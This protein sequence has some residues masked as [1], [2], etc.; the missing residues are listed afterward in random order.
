MKLYQPRNTARRR[1]AF[2]LLELI[3]AVV[4]LAVLATIAIPNYMN[5]VHEAQTATQATSL[6]S[7]AQDALTIARSNQRMLPVWTDVVT[8]AHE[9]HTVPGTTSPWTITSSTSAQPMLSFGPGMVSV[10]LTDSSQYVGFAMQST[11]LYCIMVRADASRTQVW[12]Y[13]QSLWS[14]CDGSVALAGP[15]QPT[16]TPAFNFPSPI[17][18][19]PQ[20]SAGNVVVSW[21]SGTL[22]TTSNGSPVTSYIGWIQANGVWSQVASFSPGATS[23]SV[24]VVINTYYMAGVQPVTASGAGPFIPGNASTCYQ[25]TTAQP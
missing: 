16:P 2:T 23:F 24:P 4:I 12:T 8:A 6:N 13:P 25:C 7:L 15:S 9:T 18:L 10:D 14:S 17:N 22:P 5:T 3:I 19:F 20:V 21:A 11:P 1:R